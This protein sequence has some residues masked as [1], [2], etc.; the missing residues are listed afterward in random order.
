L[1]LDDAALARY[2]VRLLQVGMV[3]PLEPGIINTFAQGLEEIIVVEEKRAFLELFVRDIL[4]GR[5][6]CPRVIG[7]QDEQARAFIPAGGDLDADRLAPL[8]AKRL[9]QRVPRAALEG[10]LTFLRA[11]AAGPI[12]PLLATAPRTAYFCS[13]C[14]HNRSTVVPD[15]SLAGGGIGCHGLALGM[16][17][18]TIG[19]GHMGGEGAQWV[20]IAP[21]TNTPHLFQ[22][23]GDGTLFHSGSLAIRQAI[24]AN[25]NITYKILFNS[26]VGMTGGQAVDGGISAPALTRTLEAEGVK[27]IIVTTDDPKKYPRDAGW[28]AGVR[29]WH[30]DRLDEAQRVL[31]DTP[32]VTALIHDQMCAA[33]LRRRRKRGNAPEPATR[34]F[35]NE[36][37]CEGCGDCGAK[38]NC[39]SVR[40]VE[41]EF[42]RKTQIHQSSCNK[43]YSCLLGDCPAFVT[44]EPQQ[45]S[46][47]QQRKHTQIDDRFPE[48]SAKFG[49]A[50]NIFMMGIGGTGVVTVN[51][52]LGTAALLDGKQID[53][54]DQTGLSQKG[55]QVVS[56]LKISAAPLAGSN[57]LSAGAADC[58][59]G[60]DILTAT[61]PPNLSRASADRTIAVVS[62]SQVPTGAMVASIEVLFPNQNLLTERIN[63][64]TRA[65]M[66]V[67]FD[68]IALAE[69]CFGDHLAANMIVIGTAYQSGLIPIAAAAIERAIDL[70]GVAVQMNTQAFRLGRRVVADP[71]WLREHAPGRIGAL[72][73]PPNVSWAARK[74]IESVGAEGELLR[75]LEIRVPELI[76]YQGAGYAREYSAFVARVRAAERAATPGQ[77]SLSEA[78]AR[79]L[80]KLMAYKDEY[81][82]A[83]LHL[84]SGLSQTLAETFGADVRLHY[85]LH[86]P[87]LRA[88]GWKKKI[89]LGKWFDIGYQIL[90]HAKVLRG[91]RLDP[92]GHTAI[93]QIERALIGEYRS[94][95]E[96]ALAELSPATYERAV[97]LAA[98]PDMIRGYEDVKLRNVERFR[99]AVGELGFGRAPANAR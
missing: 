55:G 85:H 65:D 49:S 72:S 8:L 74:L 26:A 3:F 98:L 32:G 40:P 42:G 17:R 90:M 1:G 15:G 38:S 22:N 82:V 95:I 97:K 60:F 99:A 12:I 48:P 16:D 92:F 83:R 43:D 36:A 28:A 13:G 4:Y 78:V 69:S 33:E 7:K 21:F 73:S 54:M 14:P 11:Q 64:H 84:N 75:L 24:A 62:T 79:Y 93:R 57:R 96:H 52:I 2:G 18:D 58:Y 25:A 81:E 29:I 44:V 56:N 45:V 91:T 71:A 94:L 37:V 66:N 61:T 70:N 77:T 31:R 5:A 39:L 53:G 86:P 59:I 46:A 23:L 20:G 63:Q 89:K 47:Q 10:R 19:L 51:Q 68:A 27:Q 35:I 41:T 6:D 50:A 34:V 67:F 87:F 80:F 9:E 30:R 88:L 76:A